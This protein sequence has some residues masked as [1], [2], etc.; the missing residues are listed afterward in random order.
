VGRPRRSPEFY[1]DAV[2]RAPGLAAEAV[3][4]RVD[5]GPGCSVKDSFGDLDLGSHGFHELF[6]AQW[7]FREP[8]APTATQLR[9]ATVQTAGDLADW[10]RAAHLEGTIR[11]ELLHDEAVRILAGVEVA[12]VLSTVGHP[13]VLE[14]EDEAAVDI[15]VLAVSLAAVVW[16]PI[17]RPSSSAVTCPASVDAVTCSGSDIVPDCPGEGGLCSSRSISCGGDFLRPR[18]RGQP[19]QSRRHGRGRAYSE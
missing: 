8:A 14:L 11:S 2:T 12:K 10:T 1:P 6:R 17:T 3:L 18:A 9:W 4:E 15:E 16:I 13:A 5:D 7:I 19:V